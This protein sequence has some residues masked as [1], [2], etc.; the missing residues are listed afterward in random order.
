[1]TAERSS[2]DQLKFIRN[3]SRDYSQDDPLSGAPSLP[4]EGSPDTAGLEVANDALDRARSAPVPIHGQ[5]QV[6]DCIDQ[7]HT[8]P[9]P[10][11]PQA[12]M[13][14]RLLDEE[15]KE[16]ARF[17]TLTLDL[18]RRIDRYKGR[19]LG[20]PTNHAVPRLD[21]LE[22]FSQILLNNHGDPR[23]RSGY[24]LQTHACEEWV[25]QFLAPRLGITYTENNGAMWPGTTNAIEHALMIARDLIGRGVVGFYCENAHYCAEDLFHVLAIPSVVV[26]EDPS[27]AMN[28]D[29]LEVK[30]RKETR[31]RTHSRAIIF[32]TVGTTWKGATDDIPKIGQ[33]IHDVGLERF[34]LHVDAALFGFI[35]PFLDRVPAW[36]FRVPEV[37]SVAVSAH[38]FL[39]GPVAGIGLLRRQRIGELLQ[40]AP[41][42]NV[43]RYGRMIDYTDSSN[44]V[45]IGSRDGNAPLRV[46]FL[47]NS[48]REH[49]LRRWAHQCMQIADDAVRRFDA[50]GLKPRRNPFSNVVTFNRPPKWVIEKYVLMTNE[51]EPNRAQMFVM[52]H[53]TKELIDQL[54][55]DITG[56]RSKT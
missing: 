29:D 49:G 15:A 36:N 27:G 26:A 48:I 41:A 10:I 40:G 54:L 20:K 43:T 5:E 30:L 47:L 6:A 12:P 9:A 50:H 44:L 52:P 31:R 53:V 38:K 24:P 18:G 35:L 14:L 22:E 11:T 1:M 39:G 42:R 46:G 55:V 19:I 13:L 37:S 3:A 45:N 4:V 7:N 8:T 51:R 33:L 28:L 2:E 23:D 32:T 25:L 21:G 17:T 34:W 56:Y 16:A